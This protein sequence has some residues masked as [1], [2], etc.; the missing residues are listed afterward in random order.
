M[1]ADFWQMLGMLLLVFTPM[2]IPLSVLVLIVP[3]VV[4]KIN[5]KKKDRQ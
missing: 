3:P 1:N 5:G 4:K 2:L